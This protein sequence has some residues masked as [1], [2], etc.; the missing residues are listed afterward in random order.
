[1]SEH[2]RPDVLGQLG[3]LAADERREVLRHLAGCAPCRARAAADDPAALFALLALEPLPAGALDRLELALERRVDD[4]D[5]GPRSA[6]RIWAAAGLA[7]SLLLAVLVGV[8]SGPVEPPSPPAVEASLSV[9]DERLPERG[10]ELLS[11]PPGD[12]QVVDLAVGEAHVVILFA[13]GLEL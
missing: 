13:E 12:T 3:D 6:R 1:V 7:A 5:A 11:A 9:P 8:Q 10:V 2:P 4:A